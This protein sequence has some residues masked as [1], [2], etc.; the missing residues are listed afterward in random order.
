VFLDL[1]VVVVV[2]DLRQRL[3]P[4]HHSRNRHNPR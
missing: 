1:V 3:R 4:Q 2:V